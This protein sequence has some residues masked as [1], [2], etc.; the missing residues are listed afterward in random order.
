ML[1]LAVVRSIFEMSRKVVFANVLL[2]VL[3]PQPI[4]GSACNLCE[5]VL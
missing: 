2:D 1:Q 4:S 3:D 5:W